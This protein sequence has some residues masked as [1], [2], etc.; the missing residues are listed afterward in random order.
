MANKIIKETKDNEEQNIKT[1]EPKIKPDRK[2]SDEENEERKALID[3]IYLLFNVST[4][5]SYP[6]VYKN[7]KTFVEEFGYTYKGIQ[8]T[9]SFYYKILNNPVPDKPTVGIVPYYYKKATEYFSND[10]GLRDLLE[11]INELFGIKGNEVDPLVYNLITKYHNQMGCT[12]QGMKA[13]LDYYYNILENNLPEKPNVWCIPYYYSA[14]KEF[15]ANKKSI[16]IEGTP[17]KIPVINV[18]VNEKNR[19]NFQ[20]EFEERWRNPKNKISI[21][22]IEVDEDEIFEDV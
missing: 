11:Y 6:T 20:A 1:E 22:E 4:K 21:S 9:L 17:Q 18:Y 5:K 19:Q 12:F 16:K 2:L 14:A 8:D 3:Y 15:Y 10:T 7:I 13:T